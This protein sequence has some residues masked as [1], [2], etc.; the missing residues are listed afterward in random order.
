[1][2]SAVSP[3][4]SVR[5]AELLRTT[6][7]AAD[8]VLRGRYDHLLPAAG[9]PTDGRWF[10]RIRSTAEVDV[11]LISWVPGHS[12]E[13]HD[14]AGSSGALTVLAGSLDEYRWDHGRLRRRRLA[15]GDQAAFPTG[16]VHDVVGAP[17]SAGAP[18]SAGPTLSVHAY[19]PP[20]TAMNYYEVAGGQLRRTRI[21]QT[22]HP[23]AS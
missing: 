10:T 6:D 23:E 19:S 12:T 13:L 9:L 14:H 2:I 18:A 4:G 21:E 20:L 15:A 5:P 16:W 8:A 1:M 11:W 17:E 7:L 3:V 22:A